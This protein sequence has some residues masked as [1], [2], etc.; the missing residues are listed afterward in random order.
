M[1]I[2]LKAINKDGGGFLYLEKKFLRA[3]G[4]KMKQDIF[5]SLQIRK[6]R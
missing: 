5:V 3:S 4:V 6:V 1:K 2:F